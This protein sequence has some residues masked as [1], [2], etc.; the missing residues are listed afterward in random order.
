ML[1]DFIVK[2]RAGLVGMAALLLSSGLSPGVSLASDSELLKAV[3]IGD[4]AAIRASAP[5]AIDVDIS[6]HNGKNA[7]MVAAKLGDDQ[8]VNYLLSLGADPNAEN[9]NGGTPIMFAAISG[10]V[11]IIKQLIGLDVDVNLKGSNGWG[12]LMIASAKG[13]I[14]A[15]RLLIKAGADV[16]TRDVYLWTPLHRAAYE[17]RK[18]IVA[19]LLTH[20]A[21]E[22]EAKDDQGAT[23]LHHA[24]AQGHSEVAVS[25]IASG[26]SL[27]QQDI[28][29]RTALQYA[30]EKGHPQLV[31]L[32]R[33][34]QS[35]IN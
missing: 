4:L 18:D 3:R 10:N 13:H 5:N 7:L 34:A 6:D 9:N 12:A 29:G 2:T 23:A 21:I 8:T 24:A 15:T 30:A 20:P 22:P 25:L 31:E 1:Q 32:L 33:D 19:Q 11:S 35:Q 26:M 27:T 16:N 17:N 28:A 14:E